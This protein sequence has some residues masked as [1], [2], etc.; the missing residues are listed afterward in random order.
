LSTN[1][2]DGRGGISFLGLG[3]FRQ[4]TLVVSG[5]G[6]SPSLAASAKSSLGSYR[7]KNRVFTLNTSMIRGI[8]YT[9]IVDDIG[10]DFSG[11]R[12]CF[13]EVQIPNI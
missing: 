6:E 8:D 1:Y 9:R 11:E 10:E 7:K 4:V 5:A 12:R 13:I 3:Y 2:A